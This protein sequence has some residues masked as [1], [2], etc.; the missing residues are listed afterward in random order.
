MPLTMAYVY[1]ILKA[2]GLINNLK[3]THSGKKGGRVK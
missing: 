3:T 1:D 2:G